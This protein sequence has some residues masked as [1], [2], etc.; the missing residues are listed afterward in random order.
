M[1]LSAHFDL[2]EF[3]VSQ[4]AARRGI[5]NEPSIA[6]LAELQKT[7]ELMERV[8]A[9]L[10]KPIF[11]TSGFRC[12]ALNDVL[13]GSSRTSAHMWGGAAD[14]ICPGYGS[15]LD[16]CRELQHYKE[17]LNFDQL[18]W[19]LTWVHIGR[20]PAGRQP[21]RQLRIIDGQ[22]DREVDAFP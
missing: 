20:A 2:A 11:I 6:A 5:A 10:E 9:R 18:I 1:K 21:R 19:E 4:E 13:P 16:V 3:T 8:R 22:G 7:A 14:F 12:Q 15:P 17:A